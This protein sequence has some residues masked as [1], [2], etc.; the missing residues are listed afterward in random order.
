M[1]KTSFLRVFAFLGIISLVVWGCG[2]WFGAKRQDKQQERAKAAAAADS[3]AHL[4][5]TDTT[6]VK[7]D[8]AWLNAILITPQLKNDNPL[9][10]SITDYVGTDGSIR[11]FKQDPPISAEDLLGKYKT[12]LGLGPDDELRPGA[13]LGLYPMG[14]TRTISNIT[15]VCQ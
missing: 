3:T 4:A 10:K 11:H 1:K 5:K 8:S 7:V 13:I 12:A 9:L 6:T 15:R 2:G 14:I